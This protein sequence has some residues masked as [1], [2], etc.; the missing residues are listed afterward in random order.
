MREFHFTD[1]A[2]EQFI[3]RWEPN[4]TIEQARDEMSILLETSKQAGK[5]IT[6]D[7]IFVSGYRSEIRFVVKDRNVCITVLPPGKVDTAELQAEFNELYEEYIKDR[8][9]MNDRVAEMEAEILAIDKR[10]QE[11]DLERIELGKRKS[12][13]HN[14]LQSMK[15]KV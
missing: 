3:R 5:T 2:I 9:P 1:H 13:L 11:I 10:R 7:A 12:L 14:E 6:G 8:P 4:K 15:Y